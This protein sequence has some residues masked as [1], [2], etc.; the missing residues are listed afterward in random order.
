MQYAQVLEKMKSISFDGKSG[1]IKLDQSGDLF[2]ASTAFTNYRFPSLAPF[3]TNQTVDVISSQQLI[4]SHNGSLQTG[5][6]Q[7]EHRKDWHLRN[8]N[9]EV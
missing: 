1:I 6:W 2:P 4:E 5:R 8:S 9:Q 3:S 7:N